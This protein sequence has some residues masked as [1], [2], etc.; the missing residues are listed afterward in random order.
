M[1]TEILRA[2][3]QNG[4]LIELDAGSAQVVAG[5][6]RVVV[7]ADGDSLAWGVIKITDSESSPMVNEFIEIATSEGSLYFIE[8]MPRTDSSET[9]EHFDFFACN[10]LNTDRFRR[11]GMPYAR[12]LLD[13]L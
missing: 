12:Q 10:A 11:D 2:A 3:A 4:S 5:V 9:V 1:A 13:S 8:N 7:P 6:N